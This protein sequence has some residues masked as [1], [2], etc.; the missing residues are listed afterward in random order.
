[1]TRN[2]DKIS[3]LQTCFILVSSAGIFDHV[4]IIPILLQEAGR[5][6]W[7]SVLSTFFPFV[8]WIYL[9]VYI[10]RKTGKQQLSVWLQ[11][12]AGT[13]IARIFSFLA[14]LQLF[15]MA[16]VTLRDTTVWTNVT[17]LPKTPNLL[18]VFLFASV[19]FYA[20]YSGIQTIAIVNGVLLSFVIL[21]GLFVAISNIPNKDYTLLFPVL[22]HGLDPLLRGMQIT[23]VAFSELILVLFIQH[24]IR[25]TVTARALILTC[26]VYANLIL[27]P[28]TGAIAEFGTSEAASLR[29]T[30]FEEWR[31]VTFGHYLEHVDFL[32]VYQ[33]LVGSFIRIS[34]ILFLLPEVFQLPAGKKRT[35]LLLTVSAVMV[36]VTQIPVSDMQFVRFLKNIF[37]PVSLA[38][39]IVLLLFLTIVTIV[40]PY[41]K[42][43]KR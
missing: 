2:E 25:S 39:T 36:A 22:A 7:V 24:R 6:A 29:F 35:V 37:L 34:F 41:R 16:A 3:L 1:M 20:A 33:W 28:L 18:L 17:Y 26:A 19:C 15:S 10:I 23:A 12:H 21:F 11:Q 4:M 40:M 9:L 38:L 43:M 32:S 31:L 13:G 27:S 30:A 42:V 14:A 5:D 8:A